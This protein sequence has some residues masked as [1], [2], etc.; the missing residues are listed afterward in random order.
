MYNATYIYI[1]VCVVVDFC[2]RISWW[3]ETEEKIAL[4]FLILVR[5]SSRYFVLLWPFIKKRSILLYRRERERD[6]S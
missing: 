2:V 3:R 6:T 1:Y 5:S 4:E